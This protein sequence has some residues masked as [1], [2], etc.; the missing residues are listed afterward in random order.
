MAPSSSNQNNNNMKNKF[1]KNHGGRD[2]Y[3]EIKNRKDYVN[4]CAIRATAIFLDLPYHEVRDDLFEIAR[5]RFDMPNSD[6]VIYEYLER[7]DCKLNKT[8]YKNGKSKFTV[9]DFPVNT[10]R[11]MIRV[12][13]HWTTIVDEVV[14]D[15]WDCRRRFA[16]RYFTRS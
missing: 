14:Q 16:G 6:A 11:V 5:E 15:T 13:R 12:A 2:E 9:G 7:K 1:Q 4:D 3:V 8:I 10:N